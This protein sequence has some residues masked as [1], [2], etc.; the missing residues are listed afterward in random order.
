MTQMMGGYPQ[1]QMKSSVHDKLLGRN[2]GT[3][4]CFTPLSRVEEA[5]K[6]LKANLVA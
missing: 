6:G 4:P 1:I 3:H 5:E 2:E